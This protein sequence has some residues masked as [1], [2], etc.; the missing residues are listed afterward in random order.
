MENR[1]QFDMFYDTDGDEA[2][3]RSSGPPLI[4][5]IRTQDSI[6]KSILTFGASREKSAPAGDAA[7]GGDYSDED[8]EIEVGDGCY[9]PRSLFTFKALVFDTNSQNIVAP[10]MNVGS[11]RS[12]NILS[13]QNI[14]AARERIP[15]LPAVYLVEPT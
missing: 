14:T 2:F 13:H 15:D 7:D 10:I 12:C 1:N 8:P 6:L 4:N 11:L 5:L 9:V 3:R